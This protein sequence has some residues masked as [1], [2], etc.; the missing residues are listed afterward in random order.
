MYMQWTGSYQTRLQLIADVVCLLT[1][2]MS[3]GSHEI[4]SSC[5]CYSF[6]HKCYIVAT[7]D[8]DLKRRI[9]KVPGVPIM[10]ISQHKYMLVYML[11]M[12][13]IFFIIF[14]FVFVFV[15]ALLCFVW[16]CFYSF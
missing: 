11:T 14:L 8:R 5:L 4:I 13:M 6:Q 15:V 1:H 9:R 7:C 3:V 10:Y 16:F 2:I 12:S